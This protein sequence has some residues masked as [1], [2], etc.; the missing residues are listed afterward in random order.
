MNSA[1]KRT[2]RG[3]GA[4]FVCA[5]LIAVVSVCAGAAPAG[6][7]KVDPGDATWHIGLVELWGKDKKGQP[8]SLD[9]YPVFERGKCL[10]ALATARRFTSLMPASVKMLSSL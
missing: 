9:I 1:S 6:A 3:D 8:R 4:R 7:P 2:L 10:R 5:A